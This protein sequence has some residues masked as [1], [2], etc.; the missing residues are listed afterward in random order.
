MAKFRSARGAL[1]VCAATFVGLLTVG[2]PPVSADDFTMFF[3]PSGTF[4]GTAPAG[5]LSAEFTDVAA[6]MVRLV[7]TS[8]LAAGENLDPNKALYLNIDP[9]DSALLGSIT[10][11][12][13]ANTGF[14]QAAAVMES[15][16]AFKPDGDGLYDILFTYSPSTKAFTTGQSQTYLITGTG[17][18]A[19]D[20]LFL[21]T[22]GSGCGTGSTLAAVHVQ[23]TP[24]GGNGSAFVGAVLLP[25]P[26]SMGLLGTALL[27]AYG[28]LRRKLLG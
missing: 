3:G 1:I 20:F 27:G 23:N 15:E 2:A 4:S 16:D 21:S 24:A 25:E 17:L 28:L 6:N 22:C 19:D 11:T 9:A 14:S 18:N 10:F 8:S 26:A 5:S 7:I 12:L 13:K